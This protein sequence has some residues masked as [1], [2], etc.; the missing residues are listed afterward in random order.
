MR[1]MQVSGASNNRISIG[2]GF[3]DGNYQNVTSVDEIRHFWGIKIS[4]Y[5]PEESAAE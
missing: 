3:S 2:S 1:F 4:R 5:I